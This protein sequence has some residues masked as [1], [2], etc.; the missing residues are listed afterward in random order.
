M[1]IRVTL[2]DI[3]A[4]SGYSR[5]T[6]SL[7]MQNNPVVAEDTRVAIQKAVGELGYV[8][9]RA[10]ASLRSQQSGIFGLVVSNLSN[11]FFAE[12]IL[13]IEKVI[14]SEERTV[15]LGQHSENLVSQERMLRKMLEARVDGILLVATRNT[16]KK[17]FDLLDKWGIPTVLLTRHVAKVKIPYVGPNNTELAEIATDH[18]FFH[19]REKIAFIGGQLDTQVH[20]E[21][22]RGVLNSAKKH[23]VDAKDVIVLGE[24]STRNAGYSLTQSLLTKHNKKLGILTYNDIVAFGVLAALRD[25]NVNIGKDI[26][27][28]GIDDVVGAKY[29]SP[30]LTS[31]HLESEKIGQ[32]AA[33]M[34]LKLS[35]GEAVKKREIIID[36]YLVIRESCGCK[37]TQGRT[38]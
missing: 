2:K 28:I 33:E 31:V 24:D 36:G 29:E 37:S 34:L 1:K 13:G 32:A 38:S 20:D 17:T 27:V 19:N 6:V 21:R 16:D 12:L 15:L 14:E 7:V 25:S 8:Y 22:L 18:L 4:Y 26:S 10:A 3:A 23:G 11:P 9:N 30:A 5:S 35:K